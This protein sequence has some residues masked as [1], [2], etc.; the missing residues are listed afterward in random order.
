M[1][2]T[3]TIKQLSEAQKAEKLFWGLLL[4]W[5]ICDLFQAMFMEVMSDEAYYALYGQ[6]LAWGYYDHPPMVALSNF[7][8]SCLFS[9]NL[10]VR[11]INV[12]L[13]AATIWIVWKILPDRK[14]VSNVWL[15]FAITAS[16][17]MFSAYGFITTPDTPLLFFT[18]SFLFFYKKFL[19]KESWTITLLLIVSMAGMFYS[20]YHAILVIGLVV[21]SN[22]RLLAKPKFWFCF[23]MTTLL[24]LPHIY[25]Q[26]ANDFP[27][28]K[29][30]LLT[31][32][33]GPD[34]EN[35]LTFL[36]G[37]LGVFNPV[38]LVGIIY[39]LIKKKCHDLFDRALY[40]FTAG[41]LIF[42]QIMIFRGRVE[43]HWTV[44][45]TIPM[46][47]LLY[48]VSLQ[49]KKFG[50]IIFKSAL[51]IIPLILV[52]RIVLAAGIL[53][54]SFALNDKKQKYQA[55]EKAAGS[56]PVVFYG[57]FQAP[58][59]YHYFTGKPG[60]VLS[61]HPIRKTQYDI[62]E[63]DKAYQDSAVFIYSGD[64]DD[65]NKYVIDG[66]EFYGFKIQH[67]QTTNHVRITFSGLP[68]EARAGDTLRIHYT[69]ENPYS[70][71]ID[72][73][74]PELP[75]EFRSVYNGPGKVI[76]TS[77][78]H[79]KPEFRILKA[80]ET[81]EGDLLTVVP[82]VAPSSGYLFG[83][84]LRTPICLPYNSSYLKINIVE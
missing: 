5:V 73:D 52:A 72:M 55:I 56:L 19:E 27:S 65:A 26:I 37:Q 80:G 78:C 82:P 17:V 83:L 33:K 16:F 6:N 38:A 8:S 59:L 50:R 75:V 62:W 66:T 7:L 48:K 84:S 1:T 21:L 22:L 34:L 23:L 9:G 28:F 68:D 47:L 74:H 43:A 2:T 51:W 31:R 35:I 36:P 76:T 45:A 54:K 13:H 70:K 57:S 44:V 60:F 12:V 40:F 24:F 14:K 58:S 29:Y 30:H 71:D 42:F 41:I 67:L 63:F 18:A 39:I 4:I 49:D 64:Q 46:I 77:L 81:I 20:K 15:F 25:W 69:M 11:F 32:S 53:P 10:S 79:Y 61:S 3:N